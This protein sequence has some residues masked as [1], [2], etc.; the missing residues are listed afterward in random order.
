[1]TTK[2]LALSCDCFFLKGLQ[3]VSK[4]WVMRWGGEFSCTELKIWPVNL[5][6]SNSWTC[7]NLKPYDDGCLRRRDY[8][9]YCCWNIDLTFEKYYLK[10]ILILRHTLFSQ[11]CF[12]FTFYFSFHSISNGL[13]ESL[14]LSNPRS[15]NTDQFLVSRT[16]RQKTHF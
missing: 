14:H 2:T 12:S 16:L 4:N 15:L 5:G 3:Y 13:F 11:F 8:I 1:M 6:F 7:A 10:V 9:N